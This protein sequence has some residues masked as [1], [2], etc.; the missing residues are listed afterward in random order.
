MFRNYLKVA[1]RTLWKNRTHTLINI[2][3]L[4]VAFGT[5]VLLFLTATFEL[6]YDRF[7]TDGDRIFRLYF[8]SSNR[9]GTP[10]KSA[11]MPYPISP[12][13][14][15]EFP[16]IEGVSRY[17]NRGTSVR[18]KSQTYK[19][20]VR[21]ADPDFLH[22]FT[23]P[24]QKG[25]PK[26][27]LNSLSDIVISENMAKDIFG[28][29]N[30][31]GKPLQLRMNDTWQAFTV[32]GVVS[33]AP[34]N[35]TFDFDAFIRSE[36]AADYQEF[37]TRWDHGNHDVY[38]K[39]KAGTDPQTLQR[40]TQAFI[41]KYF[42]QD[43]KEQK[44]QGYPKNELGFPEKPCFWSRCGMYISI[45]KQ[46]MEKALVGLTSTRCYSLACSFWRLPAS[47][48]S[49]SPL[50]NR[51]RGRGRWAFGSRWAHKAGNFSGKSGAKRCYSL[52]LRY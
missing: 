48:S 8:L 19:K 12:A 11:T 32:T 1:F 20:D 16:E 52:L 43:I 7:H 42:A 49:T 18:R 4:S 38:V 24:L 31:I 29:E 6:S 39:L 2:V 36:T 13:L 28:A 23:F 15:A 22:M 34:K 21:L 41:D 26:T 9:D 33:N 3:G 30:P 35:S 5:C 47:I 25:S 40:R 45:P 51:S 46:R 50:P 17:F 10:D 37:K 44:E 27:A 14:K